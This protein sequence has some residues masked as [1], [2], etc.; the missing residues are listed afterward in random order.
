LRLARPASRLAAVKLVAHAAAGIGR[1]ALL[2]GAGCQPREKDK[3]PWRDGAEHLVMPP[4]HFM[5]RLAAPL[6]RP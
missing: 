4:L 2:S 1:M 6:K 5:Q 3:T